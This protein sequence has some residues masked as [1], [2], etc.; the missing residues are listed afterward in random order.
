MCS[1]MLRIKKYFFHIVCTTECCIV[2][3]AGALMLYLGNDGLTSWIF[4][5]FKDA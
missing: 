5:K 2:P 3:T 1:F 4:L